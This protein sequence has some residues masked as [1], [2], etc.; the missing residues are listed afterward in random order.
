MLREVDGAQG[1]IYGAQGYRSF[2]MAAVTPA[3]A[4]K[5]NFTG[6]IPVVQFPIYSEIFSVDDSLVVCL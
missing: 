4:L 1:V 3:T 5:V 6:L 2:T